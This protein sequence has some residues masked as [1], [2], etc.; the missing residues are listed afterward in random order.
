[1]GP[2]KGHLFKLDFLS[3]KF[4]VKFFWGGWVSEP[5]APPPPSYTKPDSHAPLHHC[6]TLIGICGPLPILRC[7]AQGDLWSSRAKQALVAQEVV[8]PHWYFLRTEWHETLIL[9]VLSGNEPAVRALIETR[10]AGDTPEVQEKVCA[11]KGRA[12]GTIGSGQSVARSLSVA[13]LA[14]EPMAELC[15]YL[16]TFAN[17]LVCLIHV[18]H[19]HGI[20]VEDVQTSE[21]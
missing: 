10:F 19:H 3:A 6:W 8:N 1:M 12:E 5:K 13:S 17:I 11:T 16:P 7:C 15:A 14:K 4:W 2:T 9:A 20:A 21:L 18:C